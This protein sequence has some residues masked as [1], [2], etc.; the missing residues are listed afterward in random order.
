MRH[1]VCTGECGSAFEE[2]GLCESPDCSQNGV[3]REQCDC[4][5]GYHGAIFAEMNSETD[6]EL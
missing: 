5:D 3:P 1:Y 6:P 4:T 2:P